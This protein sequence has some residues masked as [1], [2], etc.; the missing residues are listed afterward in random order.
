MEARRSASAARRT[1]GMRVR[2]APRARSRPPPRRERWRSDPGASFS[3]SL[4]LSLPIPQRSLQSKGKPVWGF[5]SLKPE[6]PLP[7]ALSPSYLGHRTPGA[8]PC[9]VPAAEEE[10]AAGK[11]PAFSSCLP[12]SRGR[13]GERRMLRERRGALPFP[14][15]PTEAGAGPRKGSSRSATLFSS[16]GGASAPAS[17]GS[18][19]AQRREL[20]SFA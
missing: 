6:H 11:P 10:D 16:P 12:F 8:A 7:P 20:E 13:G 19:P 4:S 17:P 3:T 15:A 1:Q 5:S 14:A 9:R 18:P 2:G